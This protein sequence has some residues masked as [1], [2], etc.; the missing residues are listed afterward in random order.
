[1]IIA[2]R[3]DA[4][5][6]RNKRRNGRAFSSTPPEV[7]IYHSELSAIS[8]SFGSSSIWI[9]MRSVNSI[10]DVSKQESEN[11][12]VL[13]RKEVFSHGRVLEKVSLLKRS[14]DGMSQL[15][16]EIIIQMNS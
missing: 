13:G 6:I 16:I 7:V 15:F 5:F 8:G 9:S 4:P 14:R 10:V 2:S 3:W 11:N 12:I 1:M